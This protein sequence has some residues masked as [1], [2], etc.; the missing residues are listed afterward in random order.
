[1]NS[2]IDITNTAVVLD[3]VENEDQQMREEF[4]EYLQQQHQNQI[5]YNNNNNT[6]QAGGSNYQMRILRS[7]NL[8]DY[9]IN[10]KV[11]EFTPLKDRNQTFPEAIKSLNDFFNQVHSNFVQPMRNIQL[12]QIEFNHESFLYPVEVGFLSKDDMTIEMMQNEFEC[13]A[14]SYKHIDENQIAK[15]Q[16]FHV[17]I[18]ILNKV[19]E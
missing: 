8:D 15:K 9:N 17:K 10:E 19:T 14:Q 4:H 3:P 18:A 13:I 2:S 16:R 7:N 1:M 6:T 12:I 5:N 11:V